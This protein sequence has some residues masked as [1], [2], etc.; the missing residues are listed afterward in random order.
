MSRKERHGPASSSPVS[1]SGSPGPYVRSAVRSVA[2]LQQRAGNRA[3]I[4]MLDRFEG[5]PAVQRFKADEHEW[6]GN[7]GSGGATVPL[8]G[9]YT[10]TFGEMVA[11]A[12]DH[13]SSID[14][15]RAFARKKA[16]GPGG[17]DELEYVRRVDIHGEEVPDDYKEL[18]DVER[19]RLAHASGPGSSSAG[20]A[21]LE[22]RKLGAAAAATAQKR[23]Y[24][25]AGKNQSHFLQPRGNRSPLADPAHALLVA[26]LLAAAGVPPGFAM[27]GAAANY[28]N[29]HVRA[30]KEAVEAGQTG[31]TVAPALA[32]EAFGAHYL[33]DS[34]AGGHV[35]TERL[36]ISEHWNTRM[37][38]FPEN[39]VGYISETMAKAYAATVTVAGLQLRPDVAYHFGAR[40]KVEA[41]LAS[42]GTFTFGDVISGAVHDIANAQGVKAAVETGVS[43]ELV[44]L[45]GDGHLGEG[46]ERRFATEAVK[47]GVA[48]IRA[49]FALARKK[50]S[51]SVTKVLA[52]LAKDGQFSPEQLLP[53]VAP[54]TA[55]PMWAHENAEDLF[56]DHRMVEAIKLFAAEQ[57][58][59]LASAADDL[60]SAQKTIFMERVVMPFRV[61]P[62]SMLRKVLAWTP[63]TGGGVWGHNTDDNALDYV[64]AARK[65]EGLGSLSLEQRRRLIKDLLDGATIGD[66]EDAVM[67][68]LTSAT[69]ADA[70]TLINRFGWE[71][72]YDKID[73]FVGEE[74]AEHFP[75]AAYGP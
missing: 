59:E 32:A 12:G 66:D 34:F 62:I 7:E 13:F 54:S 1:R 26:E 53:R 40:S 73:D 31:G 51:P 60:D 47:R 52:T 6:L 55:P 8:G 33:T 36:S 22:R 42:M 44:T 72:L 23:Y 37:P 41:A 65:A 67:A 45:F 74:F 27:V 38:M 68:L 69:D 5:R 35:E 9:G 19:M 50:P 16:P 28:R 48:D 61:D 46:D 71:H 63:D 29:Y 43:T 75:K 2:G 15:M 58:S 64:N 39:L 18:S 24:A 20:L 30:I 10:L 70:R 49:A 4:Q 17:V 3:V 56:A 14:Q 25:L 21:R 57:A 11:M